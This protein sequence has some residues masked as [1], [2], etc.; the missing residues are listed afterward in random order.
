MA[1]RTVSG[2]ILATSLVAAVTVGGTYGFMVQRRVRLVDRGQI[3]RFETIP[4]SFEKSRSVSEI[5]NAGNHARV[6]DSRFIALDI[7]SQHHDVSDE[8]LLAKF[9]KGYFGG[10]VI[11]PERRTLQTLGRNLL[12]SINTVLFGVFQT[13]D[14]HLAKE[15]VKDGVDRTES[16]VDFGF[17]SDK[18]WF[19]GV[20]RFAVVRSRN[21]EGEETVQ[22][23]CQSMSC[24]PSVNKPL[25]PSWMFAFHKAYADLLFRDGVSEIKRWMG[26]A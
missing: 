10:A 1:L 3:T 18:F 6:S 19:G 16:Y 24:N 8:V 15:Q 21:E 25:R 13:L 26:S 11:G 9:V 17:G 4:E 14:S 12:P 5:V 7:P 20:H 22:V 2:K 23:H